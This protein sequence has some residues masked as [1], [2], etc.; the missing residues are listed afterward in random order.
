MPAFHAVEPVSRRV[1]KDLSMSKRPCCRPY[2]FTD[3]AH[4]ERKNPGVG[5]DYSSLALSAA[6]AHSC[7][8][9]FGLYEAL[10]T[11]RE[12]AEKT[13]VEF[14]SDIAGIPRPRTGPDA[15]R[16]V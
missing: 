12:R 5:P 16:Q 3:K 4:Q 1:V 8:W 9:L 7:L 6:M 2:G 10:R 14:S 13:S 15:A 11:Y